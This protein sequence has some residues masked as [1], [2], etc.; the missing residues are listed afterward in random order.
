MR[1]LRLYLL[2]PFQAMLAGQPVQGFA[3]DKVRALLA[4]LAVEHHSAHSR[5]I[6]GTLLWPEANASIARTNLRK[7]LSTLRK[8]LCDVDDASPFLI[9]QRDT[10]QFNPE[11]NF[12]LDVDQLKSRLNGTFDHTQLQFK[13]CIPDLEEAVTLYRGS[14]LRGLMVNSLEFEEWL[15]TLRENLHTQVL[16]ALHELTQYYLRQ[17]EYNLAQKH[18]L[19]QVELEPY[20]EEARRALMLALSRSGQRSAALAQYE[21]CYSILAEELGVEPSHETQML[22]Q[23]IRSAGEAR[24]NNLSGQFQQLVGRQADQSEINRLLANPDCR[25]LT[26]VGIGG[27]GKTSLARQTAQQQLENFWHGVF[28]VTLTSLNHP[29]QIL[30]AIFDALAIS[31]GND[32]EVQLRDYLREKSIL[33][34]LDNFEH[35]F[36]QDCDAS[37]EALRLVNAL[38]NGTR[39]VKLLV[40]SR[41][42]L[43]LQAE[44]IY[45][46][47]GLL[48]PAES[49]S[50]GAETLPQ[51]AAIQLF[52][53][54]ARQVVPGF[55]TQTNEYPQIARICKLVEGIPLGIELAAGWVSQLA[56]QAIA[57]GIERNLD[58]LVTSQ[59]DRPGRHQSLR[60]VFEHSWK[61]LTAEERAAAR[62]ISVFRTAFSRAAARE[63]AQATPHLLVALVNKSFLRLE[64]DGE[65]S[66]HSMLKGFLVQELAIDPEEQQSTYRGHAH[67]FARFLKEREYA[68]TVQYQAAA[69]NEVGRKIGDV[70]AAWDWAIAQKDVEILSGALEGIYIYYWA[71]NQFAEGQVVCQS[72]LQA[73]ESLAESPEKQLFFARLQSRIADFHY[74]LG[75]LETADQWLQE[76]ITRLQ[77]LDAPQELAYALE[78]SSRVALWQ[79]EF[80]KAE[81]TAVTVIDLTRHSGPAQTLAQALSTLGSTVCESNCDYKAA[82]ELYIESLALYRQLENPFGIAK[83]LINQGTVY[84]DQGDF[85]RAQQ[86]YRECLKLYREIN[87][88]Y[89]ISVCL[90]NLAIVARRVGEFEQAK[91]LIEESL[92]LKRETGNRVAILHALLEIGALNTALRNFAEARGYYC[93]AMQIVQAVQ[94]SGIMFHIVLG[95]AELY[96]QMGE[97]LQATE[98]ATWIL[99]QHG[100]GQE[101]R[102]KAESLTAGLAEK[103][104]IA[105]LEQCQEYARKINPDEL[106]QVLIEG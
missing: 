83:V 99:A 31:L 9:I 16:S 20:R 62:R 33:L 40:T 17:G 80:E 54:R 49:A 50:E 18:A 59:R 70:H 52:L 36:S 85:L 56:C 46:V 64:P 74:W 101:I 92:A 44:W 13:T 37:G 63:V 34:V 4:Y 53:R 48:Y 106:I 1:D 84:H 12:W 22:Y 98:L 105:E 27:I 47:E 81:K 73:I 19:R 51:Y 6:L 71:R 91:D 93:E 55:L 96:A 65:Y 8:A 87:Y 66:L 88:V 14:F 15:L 97:T 11:S 79:G 58:F 102:S 89:G 95:F 82:T 30:P 90:N 60:A 25:I 39:H 45:P 41:E 38:L 76:S 57:D 29:S 28:W 23:R 104:G 61:L 69:L 86:R 67:N 78:L 68:L 72:A 5:E 24:P 7:A 35:L 103:L 10:V 21:R 42:R 94:A 43:C 100:I 2:G 32:P 3:Y 75:D 26:L 77:K